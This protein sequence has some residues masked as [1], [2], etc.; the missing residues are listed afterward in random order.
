M[1]QHLKS[2]FVFS[3]LFLLQNAGAQ[4]KGITPDKRMAM[5]SLHIRYFV[6]ATGLIQSGNVERVLLPTISNITFSKN[7]FEVRQTF[8]YSYGTI[9]TFNGKIKLE[10]ELLARTELAI[11][12]KKRFYP[13]SWGLYEKSNIRNITERWLGGVGLGFNILNTKQHMLSFRNG[14]AYEKTIFSVRESNDVL[15]YSAR[16]AGSHWLFARK[17][18]ISHE[19]YIQPAINKSDDFRFRT[20]W[21]INVPIWKHISLTT[22][23]DKGY[24]SVVD[25]GK[26]KNNFFMSY[27][28]SITN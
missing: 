28:L 24:E 12:Q 1:I 14:I 19:T 16:V 17:M 7:K 22:L 3:L 10:D 26:K 18:N 21:R 4:D 20:V 15:R 9:G 5:D 2:I 27:G 6:S 23:I 8:N 11:F 25:F 13:Y